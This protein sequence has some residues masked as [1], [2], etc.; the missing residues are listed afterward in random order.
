MR[1]YPLVPKDDPILNDPCNG[2][3]DFVRQDFTK[4][5]IENMKYY[6]GIG[7]AANQI[8]FDERAFAMEV[9]G[10]D[11]FIVC[12]N[13]SIIK[14]SSDVTTLREGCLSFPEGVT[15]EVERPESVVASYEV[16]CGI[17]VTR[18]FDGLSAK[19]FQH[20]LDHL[21][22]ILMTWYGKPERV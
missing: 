10:E 20:E 2:C 17:R 19:V 13:P 21:N 8:G 11:E 12:Y 6:G 9:V 5:L 7:L 16:E 4:L 18:T 22:G 1:I 3:S 14:S 15:V